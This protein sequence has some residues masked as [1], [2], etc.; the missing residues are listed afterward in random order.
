VINTTANIINMK[1]GKAARAMD[2]IFL[3]VRA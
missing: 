1:N 2:K 3:P